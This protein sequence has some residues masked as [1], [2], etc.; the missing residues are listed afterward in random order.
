[1]VG[2]NTVNRGSGVIVRAANLVLGMSAG[3]C[4][5]LF[6]LMVVRHGWTWHYL[7]FLAL[8]AHPDPVSLFPLRWGGHDTEEGHRMVAEELPRFSSRQPGVPSAD[9]TDR[10]PAGAGV[11]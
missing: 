2:A 4:L 10:E 5:G 7:L 6:L 11:R 3:L 9:A 8:A 1:M